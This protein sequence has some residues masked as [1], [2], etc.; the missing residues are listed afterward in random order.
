MNSCKSHAALGGAL[1]AP[2]QWAWQR[3]PPPPL[4]VLL[5]G[6]LLLVLLLQEAVGCSVL[7]SAARAGALAGDKQDP[8]LHLAPKLHEG[9]PAWAAWRNYSGSLLLSLLPQWGV[10]CQGY[11]APSIWIPLRCFGCLHRMKTQVLYFYFKPRY[12]VIITEE[13]SIPK[14]F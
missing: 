11:W 2:M 13:E 12:W 5:Q 1:C 7:D 6:S 10:R 8:A 4:P 14:P 9:C 3:S